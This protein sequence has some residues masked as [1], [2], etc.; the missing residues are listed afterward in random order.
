MSKEPILVS[1]SGGKDCALAL[2]EILL[3]DRYAVTLLST[4]TEGLN[5]VSMHGVHESLIDLQARSLSLPLLKAR[6]PLSCPGE[7]YGRIMGSLM[8]DQYKA[9]VRKVVFGDIFLEDV[10]RYRE[11]N[12]SRVDM[13]GVFPLWGRSSKELADTFI[14]DGFRAVVVCVDTRVLDAHLC[15]RAFDR[16]FLAR[17]PASVDSCGENG[18]F[19]SFTFD[20]PIFRGPIA[21][22]TAT[23]ARRDAPDGPPVPDG[24]FAYCDLVSE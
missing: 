18:E 24:R 21:Y 8:R 1:W 15:G 22:G 3:D 16:G 14:D 23:M 6:V 9:G 2:R 11:Q 4:V 12:L 13:T 17:L 10:R 5:S 20:G 7:E 19:H